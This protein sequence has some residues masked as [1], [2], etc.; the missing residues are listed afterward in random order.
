MGSFFSL[1]ISK[2]FSGLKNDP[3]V[4]SITTVVCGRVLSCTLDKGI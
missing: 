3:I 1:K 2:F 4:T